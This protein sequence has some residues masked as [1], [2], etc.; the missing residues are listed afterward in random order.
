[1]LLSNVGMGQVTI[2]QNYLTNYNGIPKQPPYS[3][4][5]CC[6]EVKLFTDNSTGNTIGSSAPINAGS[7]KLRV[8][9]TSGPDNGFFDE[10]N[11]TIAK[12]T[13]TLSVTNSPLTYTGSVQSATISSSV[14]GII[15]NVRYNGSAIE[16]TNAGTYTLTA[17]FAPTDALNYNN[18]IG[19]NA[20]NLV[21]NKAT[22][23]ISITNSP[24][25]Y[26][27]SAKVADLTPS[28]PGVFTN[29][30]YNGNS[31]LPGPVNAG[32]YSFTTNFIPDDQ[33]NYN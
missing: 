27:G 20:G 30:L 13:P 4:T 26:N 1:M 17:D 31:Y 7:Y 18:L 11:F 3:I 33:I 15:S 29:K 23:S 24:L 2:T 12:A 25:S 10:Q 21:I 6:N 14:I 5:G 22:P 16:P 32:T 28:V 19:T 8:T 9:F